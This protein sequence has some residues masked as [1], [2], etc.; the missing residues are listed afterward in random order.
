MRIL[1]NGEAVELEDGSTVSDLC[2]RFGFKPAGAA[3]VVN[4]EL[5]PRSE[6]GKLALQEDS[7]VEVIVLVG[8]G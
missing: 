2:E 4:G 7:A 1:L 5:V 6:Y 3:L 8:G